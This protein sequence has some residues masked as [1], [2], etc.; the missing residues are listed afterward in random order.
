MDDV[1]YGAVSRFLKENGYIKKRTINNKD[2]WFKGLDSIVL[3]NNKRVEYEY[4]EDIAIYS[5]GIHQ[6]EFD[7]WC[8]EN[9]VI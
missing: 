2:Y 4:F 8:G 9:K 7:Y 3:V 5:V 1:A 6:H